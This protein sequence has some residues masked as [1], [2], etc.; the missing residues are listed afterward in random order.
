MDYVYPPQAENA[1]LPPY[2]LVELTAAEAAEIDGRLED[3]DRDFVGYELGKKIEL[4]IRIEG[5]LVAGLLGCTTLFHIL[6]VETVWVDADC[7]RRGLGAALLAELERRAAAMG[8]NLIRLDTFDW[9][10]Y[11][12]YKSC[13]YEEIGSYTDPR[14]GYSEYF[15]VKRLK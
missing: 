10:G 15:F 1:E 2:K 8:V 4:G 14:D 13:G 3:F 9:Q 5:K 11:E 12:F 7:R 6:Y